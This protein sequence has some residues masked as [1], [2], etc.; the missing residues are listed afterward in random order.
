MAAFVGDSRLYSRA[1][2]SRCHCSQW[3]FLLRAQG[4]NWVW[5][6]WADGGP[7]VPPRVLSWSLG[8]QLILGKAPVHTER[9]CFSVGRE[10]RYFPFYI[11]EFK[12]G[13]SWGGSIGQ[14]TLPKFGGV[15]RTEALLYA[16]AKSFQ[17]FYLHPSRKFPFTTKEAKKKHLFLAEMYF[18]HFLLQRS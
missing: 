5:F 11:L 18:C 16:G 13:L 6:S 8:P 10:E 1:P 12:A 7:A 14:I 2:S 9:H 17:N 3:L 15:P 4:V